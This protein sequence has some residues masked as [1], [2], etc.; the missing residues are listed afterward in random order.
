MEGWE[1]PTPY[2]RAYGFAFNIF[3]FRIKI[4]ACNTI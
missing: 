3:S 1:P 2:I 4:C